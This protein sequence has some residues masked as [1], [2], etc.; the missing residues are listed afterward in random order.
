MRIQ[1]TTYIKYTLTHTTF[2]FLT[3]CGNTHTHIHKRIYMK[4][5]VLLRDLKLR[6]VVFSPIKSRS[7]EVRRL[8]RLL[9]VY[10]LYRRER[11]GI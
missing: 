9:I 3:Y 4:S 2:Y 8:L 5:Y 1:G 10:S 6:A 11:G 7:I